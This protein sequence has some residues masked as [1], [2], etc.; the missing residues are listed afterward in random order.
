MIERIKQLLIKE[1]IQTF[2][3]PKLRAMIFVT[4][5][6][7]LFIFGY[8]ATTDIKHIP[9]AV[10][11]RSRTIESRRLLEQFTRSGYFNLSFYCDREEELIRLLEK[12]DVKATLNIPP[13]FAASLQR[14]GGAKIQMLIDGTE[15][16][17][18]YTVLNYSTRIVN[19]YSQTIRPLPKGIPS[20][21]L[22]D[23]FWYNP[24]LESSNFFIPGVIAMLITITVI[25]FTAL[26]IVKE[27]EMG[28]IEQLMV[29][30]I[31]PVELIIG[32]TVPFGIIGIG[33]V[34]FITIAGLLWFQVPLKGSIPLLCIA[35][36]IYIINALGIGLYIS[37]V[38]KTLQQAMMSGFFYLF[39]AILLS[40]FVFPIKNMPYGFQLLTYVNPMRYFINILRGIFLRGNDISVLYPELLPMV[41]IGIF[42]FAMSVRKFKKKMD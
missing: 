37:T 33:Q 15:S 10:I 34:I 41:F 24:Q 35:T 17:T 27:R 16:T 26:A 14:T 19:N 23:R 40:G 8:A 39:P 1:F 18:S 20:I 2:R 22:E 11:D 36:V 12:S 6:L 29:T 30:P 13:D 31:R 25:N 3:E 4:P 38:C 21:K 9:L 5:F 32:K 28:T 42:I 7:Q